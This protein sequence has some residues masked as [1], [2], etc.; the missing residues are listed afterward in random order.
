VSHA[1]PVFSSPLHWGFFA[2]KAT[3]W[4]N[5][6]MSKQQQIEAAYHRYWNK[7]Q[8]RPKCLNISNI[9]I[10]TIADALLNLN[11][12]QLMVKESTNLADGEFYFE[13]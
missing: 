2:F 3:I 4:Y 5:Y 12:E 1:A 11:D 6:I 13:G 8:V 10:L 7:H 9:S